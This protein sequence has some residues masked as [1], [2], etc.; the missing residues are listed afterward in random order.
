MSDGDSYINVAYTKA[1]GEHDCLHY[2][3]STFGA[4]TVLVA[5]TSRS[6]E[7]EV[8]LT[9]FLSPNVTDRAGSLTFTNGTPDTVLAFVFTKVK[10]L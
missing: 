5:K 4:P 2:I 9:R 1:D 3:Y 7:L 10:I 8:N 6:S